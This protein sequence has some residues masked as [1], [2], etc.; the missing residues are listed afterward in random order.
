MSKRFIIAVD[1][2][3]HPQRELRKERFIGYAKGK[4]LK[5][6]NRIPSFWLLADETGEMTASQLDDDAY[7][8]FGVPCIVIELRGDSPWA[9][10]GPRDMFEWMGSRWGDEIKLTP[11]LEGA[12]MD[13]AGMPPS[14]DAPKSETPGR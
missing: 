12:L 11:A 7:D 4:G 6:W 9:G 3:A 5:W 13:M 2:A 1:N 14:A 10:H 8:I